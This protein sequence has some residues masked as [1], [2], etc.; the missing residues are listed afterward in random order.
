ME[1]Q[2]PIFERRKKL[3]V[4]KTPSM[5]VLFTN[6]DQFTHSKKNELQ[7]RIITEKPMII[8][9]SEVKIKNGREMMETDYE[10]NG[11][12]I[13]PINLER[14]PNIGRGIIIYTHN[15]IDKSTIQI[16]MDSKFEEACILEICL[17]GGANT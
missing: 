11:Y 9:V 2:A 15:S 6:T 4:L 10:I 7:K 5:K 12:T 8:A 13:R 17:R 1:T 3:K 16:K 14:N